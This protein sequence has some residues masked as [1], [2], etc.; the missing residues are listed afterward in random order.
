[1]PEKFELNSYEEELFL[2][3]DLSEVINSIWFRTG[4][5]RQIAKDFVYGMAFD[6]GLLDREQRRPYMGYCENL[7]IK[8]GMVVTIEKGTMVRMSGGRPSKPAG[9]TY[10]V[11]VHHLG[12]GVD[13]HRAYHGAIVNHQNPS[14]VWPG[15][16]GYWAEVDLNDIPEARISSDCLR[17]S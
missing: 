3:N 11:T 17:S 1:M 15:A 16:G 6:L 5:E 14:I 7:P 10:K 13:R 2:R 9:R 4:C 12:Y 8:R